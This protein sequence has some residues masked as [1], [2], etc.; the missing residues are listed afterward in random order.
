[1]SLHWSIGNF[2]HSCTLE[3]YMGEFKI[4]QVF[5][6]HI[7]FLLIQL[8][9]FTIPYP[10]H[11]DKRTT[12]F[13]NVRKV[14]ELRWFWASKGHQITVKIVKFVCRIQGAWL[15]FYIKSVN[16][17]HSILKECINWTKTTSK[18]RIIALFT[19][20]NVHLIVFFL[21]SV[22]YLNRGDKCSVSKLPILSI[23]QSII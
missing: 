22:F 12:H 1:M 18:I 15:Q 11:T 6:S 7:C 14:S 16:N 21:F 17:N 10:W 23:L 8:V 3:M 9:R 20:L 13:F 19:S 4:F 5:T 2:T